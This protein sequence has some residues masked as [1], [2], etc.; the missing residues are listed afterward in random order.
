MLR[1]DS[2]WFR[3]FARV[4]KS[5]GSALVGGTTEGS[6][7]RVDLR[8]FEGVEGVEDVEGGKDATVWLALL[9]CLFAAKEISDR[10]LSVRELKG[11]SG[12]SI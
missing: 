10:H 4:K 8:Q 5:K 11:V 12:E 1:S 3:G 6:E 9:F 2:R 7:W